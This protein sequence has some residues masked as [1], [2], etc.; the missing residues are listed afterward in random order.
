[1]LAH[2]L[3]GARIDDTPVARRAG[4]LP[5]WLAP[6]VLRQWGA[7]YGRYADGKPL[8]A[9]LR[10]PA[11]LL[12]AI[13]ARWPN[14]IEA[15]V[16]MNGSFSEAPRMVYQLGDCAVRAVRFGLSLLRPAGGAVR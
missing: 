15:T 12:S 8:A 4:R 7:R 13:R 10:R 2:Q 14:P 3:L 9:H 6:S 11:G 5:G 16:S 1:G